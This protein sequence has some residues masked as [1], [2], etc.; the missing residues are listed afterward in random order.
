[1]EKMLKSL[2]W[3]YVVLLI[4]EGALRKWVLPSLSDPLLIIRDPV[5]IG[6]YA[7]AFFSGRFPI[8]GF[9]IFTFALAMASIVASL[10]GGQTNLLVLAYGLRINYGHLPLIWVMA[11]VLTRKDVERLGSLLLLIAIPMTAIMVLQFKS[12]VYALINRGIGSEEGGQIYGAMGRI[13]PPG[14]FSFITGPQVFYPLVAAFFFY[15]AS[16]GRRLLWPLLIAAGLAVLIALPVS[17]SRT[18]ML[19]TGIVGVMFVLSMSRA[20]VG[21]GGYFKAIFTL[22]AVAVAVSFLPIFGE[23][24]EVFMARWETAA[25]GSDGDAWG[26]IISRVEG[27][28]IQPFHWAA[29]A[30]FFGHG[31]GVGSNVGARLL[32]GRVGFL[33][34]ED[35]WGKVFL[36]LGPVLGAAFIGFR[37]FLV[38]YMLLRSLQALYS[39]RDNL[40]ILIWS[41]CAFPIAL[42]QWAPPTILGF[43][44][45]GGGLLLASLNPE[46]ELEDEEE[47]NDADADHEE[48][49][50]EPETSP[51]WRE[52]Y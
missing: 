3:L 35:E 13:R 47:R 36:E 11:R 48:M 29:Q 30:P 22:G 2:I 49:P 19:A 33:L 9:I 6:I 42:S 38:G 52:R 24:R 31:I 17:I 7:L 44:V 18:V 15:Q 45:V 4:F 5:A 26:S 25:S 8:N 39:Q 43:A 46:P 23:G 14:F 21:F 40:P 1:M 51:P 16:S 50:A 20:G 27:G 41:A 37:V 34:A 28:F 10:V 32:S 12:P